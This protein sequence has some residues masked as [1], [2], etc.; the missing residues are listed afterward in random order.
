MLFCGFVY[1]STNIQLVRNAKYNGIIIFHYNLKKTV[2]L[3]SVPVSLYPFD[4]KKACPSSGDIFK[5]FFL[6]DGVLRVILYILLEHEGINVITGELKNVEGGGPRLCI[7][8]FPVG[9]TI[10]LLSMCVVFLKKIN[11]KY[12]NE[13][14]I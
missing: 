10:L 5:Y 11:F 7:V 12:G 8:T 4:N 6:P 2:L 14:E 3:P 13:E 9:S 1:S